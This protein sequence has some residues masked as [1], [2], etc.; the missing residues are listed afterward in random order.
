MIVVVIYLQRVELQPINFVCLQYDQ[1]R[2][3]F[4]CKILSSESVSCKRSWVYVYVLKGWIQNVWKCPKLLSGWA[5]YSVVNSIVAIWN[6]ME[7]ENMN[8]GSQRYE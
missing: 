7:F 8:P 5:L 1:P 3:E 2:P 6:P 4:S